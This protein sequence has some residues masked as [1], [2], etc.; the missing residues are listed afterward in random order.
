V[1]FPAWL[2][3]IVRSAP[4]TIVVGSLALLLAELRSP[5]PET[6]TTLVT[7]AGASDA[8]FTVKVIG[9]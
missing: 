6:A 7:I 2:F 8:T 5:P 9:G 1:K 4:G 3:V